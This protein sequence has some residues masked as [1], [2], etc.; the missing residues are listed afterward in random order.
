MNGTEATEKATE[1]LNAIKEGINAPV[2]GGYISTLGGRDR[3]S[4]L[5]SFSLDDKDSWANGIFEN[6]RYV[7]LHIETGGYISLCS[8]SHEIPRFRQGK[9]KNTQAIIKKINQFIKKCEVE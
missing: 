1:Q 7:K 9:T 3:P 8:Q 5:L 6:S 2:K 4:I